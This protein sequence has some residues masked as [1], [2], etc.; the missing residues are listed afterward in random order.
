VVAIRP[1]GSGRQGGSAATRLRSRLDADRADVERL[2]RK[3]S[4]DVRAPYFEDIDACIAEYDA[5][6]AVERKARSLNWLA[7]S[8]GEFQA[9]QRLLADLDEVRRA[10]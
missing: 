3:M 6:L 8:D 2:T 7:F 5:L 1:E 9:W 4:D 10:R